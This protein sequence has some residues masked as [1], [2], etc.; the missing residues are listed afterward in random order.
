MASQSDTVEGMTSQGMVFE[1]VSGPGGIVEGMVGQ[2][3]SVADVASIMV[4]Q[5]HP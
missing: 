3:D 2:E 4:G 5:G 1:D